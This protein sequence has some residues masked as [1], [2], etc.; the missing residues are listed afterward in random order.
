MLWIA[1]KND[2][3]EYFLAGTAANAPRSILAQTEFMRRNGF[4]TVAPT[5]L[6][7]S[8]AR[9]AIDMLLSRY[10]DDLIAYADC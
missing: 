10:S 4:D 6:F 3:T 7:A 2:G 1:T 8:S 9:E 5:I